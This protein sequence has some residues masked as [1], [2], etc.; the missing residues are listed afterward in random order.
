MV[1]GHA[2]PPAILQSWVDTADQVVAVDSGLFH[3]QEIE[4][5]PD[6]LVGDLDSVGSA[7]SG[8]R[9]HE[10]ANQDYSDFDKLLCWAELHEVASVTVVCGHGGRMDHSLAQFLSATRSKVFVRWIF[11]HEHAWV[12][13]GPANI[14]HSASKN[15]R[16]SLLPLTPCHAVE[17]SGVKWPLNGETIAPEGLVSLSNEASEEKV[18]VKIGVGAAV[19]FLET[20]LTELPVW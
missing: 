6:W 17:L 7:P 18:V 11:P 9:V 4:A 13:R 19:F 10:D 8:I 16:C 1:G 3:L 12:L 5:N 20:Q 14:A 2:I 15:Q